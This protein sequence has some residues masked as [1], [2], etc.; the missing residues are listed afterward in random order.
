M[1]AVRGATFDEY[2][3]I[4]VPTVSRLVSAVCGIVI[5]AEEYENRS[6]ERNRIEKY[7]EDVRLGCTELFMAHLLF[8]LRNELRPNSPTSN[9]EMDP[10]ATGRA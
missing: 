5:C 6:T 9:A 7:N 1:F 2:P 8:H 3:L 10:D 4:D